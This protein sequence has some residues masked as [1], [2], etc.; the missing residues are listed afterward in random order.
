MPDCGLIA[1][2]M[3]FIV[4]RHVGGMEWLVTQEFDTLDNALESCRKCSSD[5][6][7]ISHRIVVV[8][9]EIP[10]TQPRVTTVTRP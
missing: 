9:H 6:P 10:A 3:N 7:H 4:E 2:I 8:V 1:L 5:V